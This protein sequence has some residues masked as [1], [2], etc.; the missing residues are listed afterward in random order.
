MQLQGAMEE[1]P[2]QIRG[3]AKD[4]WRKKKEKDWYIQGA[5]NLPGTLPY[6]NWLSFRISKK[7]KIYEHLTDALLV[8]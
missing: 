7:C 5:H 1:G 2:N 6:H 8:V 4:T 3:V